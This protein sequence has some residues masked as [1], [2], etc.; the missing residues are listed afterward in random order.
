MSVKSFNFRARARTIE[1]LG[2]GQ[3]ADCPTAVSEL[4]KNA[5]DA[6]ARDVALF[7]VD[8]EYPCGALIDNGCGMSPEQIIDNW[9]IVGTESKS[10]K[11]A[12]GDEDRFGIP[13]RQTQG[14]KGIG[15]LSAAFLANVTFLVTKKL[16]GSF[17]SLLVDWRLF[18][19]P[20]LSFEDISIPFLE[21]DTIDEITIAFD[22]LKEE[23][24]KNVKFK[25]DE[26]SIKRRAW[27]R[28]SEDELENNKAEDFI[29]TQNK[30]LNFCQKSVLDE[31][32]I[33]PWKEILNKVSE[34]DGGQH[35]TALFLL[36]LRTDLSLL[37]NQG[38][39]SKDNQEIEAIQKNEPYRVC[40]RP[41]FLRECPN[42]K[43]KIYS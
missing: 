20:Y 6:Y 35:G 17:T 9:L 4:W 16:N 23:L 21:F 30:I 37:T 22:L 14:E 8:A 41:T 32:A 34:E 2:K 18:E 12:L 7:T 1:H 39:L 19:N 26:N 29:T 36:D 10:K 5:Y 25:K 24:I 11:K 27:E 3:I 43:T 40:R 33:T 28:F 42:D 38:D 15:R 13:V 31:R